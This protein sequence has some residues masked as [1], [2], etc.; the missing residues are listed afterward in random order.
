M[1]YLLTLFI[2]LLALTVSAQNRPQPAYAR[3]WK[4]ADS[5]AAKGL[6]KSALAIADRI[7]KE[8]KV[9]RNYPQVAK[10]ALY[11][12]IFRTYSDEE[13]YVQLVSSLRTDIVETPEP[14]RSVL[15]S[16]LATVYWEYFQQNRYK[17]YNRAIIGR[18]TTGKAGANPPAKPAESTADFTTWDAHRLMGAM[19][20]AYLASVEAKD[21]LQK[22]PVTDYDVLLNTGDA[23]AR[24]L[25]PTLYDLLAHRA[26]D[27]FKN[28]EYDLLK[29]VF[30]FSINQP[31][32]LT[33]PDIFAKLKIESQD[34]VSGRYQALLLFQQLL[35][36]HLA[37]ARPDALADADVERLAFVHRHSVVPGRDSLYRQVLEG[38]MAAFKNQ[39]AEA[40]YAYELANFLA[41]SDKNRGPLDKGDD[42]PGLGQPDPARWY[43]KQAAAICRDLIKRFPGTLSAKQAESLLARLLKVSYSIE[44]E[45][46]NA[47]GQPFRMLVNYQNT[48]VIKYRLVRVS[49]A[50]MEAYRNGEGDENQRR[51]R[52]AALLKRPIALE[53]TVSLP[54]D[55][56]LNRHSVEVPLSGLPIGQ[57]VML[58]TQDDTFREITE[59]VQYA[60]F[61]VSALGYVQMPPAQRMVNEIIYVTN[62]QT[63]EPVKNAEVTLI[64]L[65]PALPATKQETLLTDANGRVDIPIGLLPRETGFRYVITTG[66]DTLLSSQ[67]YQFNYGDNRQ[68]ET[69]PTYSRLFTDRAIYR[70]GQ[71]IYVKGLLYAGKDDQYISVPGQDVSVELLDQNGEQVARQTLKTNEF[72]TFT[73]TFTAPVGRLTGMMTLQTSYGSATIR[74]EEYKRPTFEVTTKPIKK[75][76]K[77]GQV[78]TVLA[79]AKT[80]SGAVVD[81]AAVRYRVTRKLRPRWD[82]WY[83]SRRG[84]YPNMSQA[85]IANGIAQTDASGNIT[86]KFTAT[87]DLEKSRQDNPVFDF[88]ITID[89]TDRAGET[90]SVTQTIQ[91]G[92]AALQVSLA[93]PAQIDQ[94]KP[95]AFPVTITNQLGEKVPAKGELAIYR[96]Q[97]PTRLLRARLWSRPDRQLLS[98]AEFE[99]LF[100]N[101]L[102]ATENDPKSWPKG[103]L[104]QQQAITAPADSLIKPAPNRYTPGEYVAELTVADSA[105]ESIKERAFFTVVNDKQPVAS[106]RADD[107]VQV[108]KATA[109]PGEEAVFWVGTAQPGWVLM[110]VE[111]KQQIV[112]QEWLKTDGRPRRVT[113]PVAETQRGGFAVHFTMVQNG[114][115]YQKTQL[116]TVPFTNKQLTIKTQTFRNKLKPGERET[117]TL[118]IDGLNKTPAEM[119]A[120]L[121]DA[122]LDVFGRLDWPT[123][124]YL[125]YTS[126]FYGWQSSSFATGS[127]N[128]VFYRYHPELPVPVRRYDQLG[129]MGYRFSPFGGRP[130]TYMFTG[131]PGV[132]DNAIR[133]TVRRIGK[134]IRGRLTY[135]SGDAVAGVTVFMKG[136]SEG[137][138]TNEKG[139]FSLVASSQKEEVSLT[140]STPGYVTS[141]R[142]IK[143]KPLTFNL[144][145]DAQAL[146]EVVVVGYGARAKQAMTGAVATQERRGGGAAEAMQD[147]GSVVELRGAVAAEQ[148]APAA[149]LIDPRRNFNETAFFMPQAR[150]DKQ[151]RVVLTFTM[152]E[153]LTRWRLLAFAHTKDLKTGTLEREIITQKEL[154]ITANAPR[155]L[156]EGDTIRLT[157][158]V[159]NLTGKQLNGTAA[160][161]L[162]DALTGEPLGQKI[163]VLNSQGA[164]SIPP[165]GGQAVGWTLVIPSGLETVTCRLTAESGLFTDGEE[166]TLPVLPNRMLVTDTKPFWVNG[167]ETRAFTLDPL[168]KLSPELPVQHERLTVEVTSNPS[169]YALQSLPY[170]ME[171]RYECAEQLFSRLYAN[172]LAAHI[173]ASKP[174]FRQLIGEW[175]KVP[176]KSPLQSNGELKAVTLENSPWLAD[177]RS[178]ADRQAKLGQ[179]LDANRMEQEQLQT[180]DKLKQLQTATGG[181]QWFGGME[182]DLPMTLHILSGLGH[183]TKLGVT[184]P[185]AVQPALAQMQASALQYADVE[186]KRWVSEQQK[187]DGKTKSKLTSAWYFSAT[188]YLYARSF[189]LDKPIDKAVLAYL[190]QRVGAEWLTQSL[191]GQALA[192]MALHRFGDTKTAE[193]ILRSLLERSRESG[194]M[195]LYWPDNT[196]GLNWYQTPIE[197]QA[198]LIEAFDEIKQDR[199]TADNMKRWLLRQKQTQA[200]SSTKATTEAVYALLLR[201]SD[202]LGTGT[203]TQVSLG[204]QPIESRVTS[205]EA[206]TGYRKV[207]YAAS[208][209]KPEMGVIQVTKIGD[210]PAWGA[211]YWQHF[212]PLDQVMPGSAG[213]SVQKT[214]YIQRDS[215]G[216]PLLST[217]ASQS[218]I[219]PGDLIKVRL[220]LKTDR[221]ME[222]VHLKDGRASGFEPVAALSGYKYQNG[223]G[224]YESPRDASTDFFLSYLP[225]GTHV[226]EYDLR[227]AQ[228]GDFSAGVATVQCFYAP[229]FSAHSAGERVRVKQ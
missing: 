158:R 21:L 18:A 20:T 117:W 107:W 106:A 142:K 97:P 90:R 72:G 154:M 130:F 218:S 29:P 103:E 54:D 9:A 24:A 82:W 122:S 16:V 189:Y 26:I 128:A 225:V 151:G 39:P 112:R 150:T 119:V 173:V 17:F 209:I 226:F 210:G 33:G 214:L 111:E 100:P 46:V 75:S 36:F 65:K 86:V 5:L 155:F 32:Y 58:T 187:V 115:L 105:G 179:L 162:T 198:Y 98:R 27:F 38:Q 217:V 186:I 3:D 53:N 62:R 159:N 89:V 185:V 42:N 220:I 140:F 8:A 174:A 153:A 15:Q 92:Y 183:L 192:A 143:Q 180:V 28:T 56:D 52:F 2:T 12:T 116:V 134:V 108:R 35:A 49:I 109:E 201:G 169:W 221:A 137:T 133:V 80:F 55:G 57:Y 93:I 13:V 160:L 190:K 34:S 123:T 127:S 202:W 51:K 172:S 14:A 73:A 213:L 204:G 168:A 129:W 197:T 118:T 87:P 211:L 208:E 83:T 184:F 101:D 48:R 76:V 181:F 37:D 176:P 223:L 205:S 177:A 219:K 145:P 66:S 166:F 78:V 124:V 44:I 10:A 7:Y 125:P 69:T 59:S 60:T 167:S 196:S 144:P 91:I 4:R 131:E 23:D 194:E 146:N 95:A 193:G 77:L 175:Q 11:K 132:L 164:L 126:T 200:W 163:K 84:G 121:Y 70:P 136:S 229:E 199:A 224:Y 152:P 178:E 182:P 203:N 47:P 113:L 139:E 170:L 67:Q 94:D 161:Q 19:T 135:K 1:N 191:Q 22:T 25:R 40:V 215:P 6:P 68:E 165:G 64:S 228:T 110:A 50:D 141:E 81:D 96:L 74:V 41:N 148:I 43:Y 79:S 227:V 85:E 104:V 63:G 157:A 212:E 207:T 156:R 147:G 61:T 216:G 71:L 195:G 102:F 30:T 149:P 114:R 31:E 99:K 45:Q 138:A 206:G 171:Y 188:Q 120:T 222:Y 88:D